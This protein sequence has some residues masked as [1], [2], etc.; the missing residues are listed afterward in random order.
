MEN[1]SL[2]ICIPTYNRAQL[3][4]ENVTELVCAIRGAHVRIYIADN[5]SSDN[6]REVVAELQDSYP[7]IHYH[8]HE[9]NIFDANFPF[10]LR[11]SSSDYAWLLGD[12]HRISAPWIQE[13]LT[14]LTSSKPDALVVNVDGPRVRDVPTKVY[15]DPN[16]LLAE[17]GW[18][19]TLVGSLIYSRALIERID[20]ERFS[21]T[22]FM[23]TAG[24]FEGIAQHDSRVLWL[25]EPVILYSRSPA[26]AVWRT[27]AFKICLEIWGNSILSLPPSYR[28]DAKL[29]CIKSHGVKSGVFTLLGFLALRRDGIYGPSVFMRYRRYF[30]FFSNVSLLALFFVS[31]V[32]RSCIRIATNAIWH[33]FRRVRRFVTSYNR[34]L[35][36]SS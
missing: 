1:N 9:E 21:G 20:F 24:L 2:S 10:V 3:L 15:T 19:M 5:A 25:N 35:G 8:R 26:R 27:D 32:P 12:K 36:M 6:T 16:D 11:Q 7:Y 4:R 17:L 31:L 22:N 33:R 34:K 29:K 18:H 14:L 30:C 13:I 23:H 28:I